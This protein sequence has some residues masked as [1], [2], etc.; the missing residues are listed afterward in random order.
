[1]TEKIEQKSKDEKFYFKNSKNLE[2]LMINLYTC[3]KIRIP[4]CLVGSTGL[5][6]TSMAR[7]FSEIIKKMIIT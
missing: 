3:S 1:M 5:G 6:K 7:A 2:N 4:F